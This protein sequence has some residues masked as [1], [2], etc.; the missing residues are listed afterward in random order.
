MEL[1]KYESL[2][3][4]R[5]IRLLYLQSGTDSEVIVQLQEH[6]LDTH[7]PYEA[8]SYTWH[9][10]EYDDSKDTVIGAGR[11]NIWVLCNGRRMVATDWDFRRED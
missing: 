11:T 5:S 2:H 1:Y 8:P 4:E 10:P 7:P 9:S 6:S 3:G